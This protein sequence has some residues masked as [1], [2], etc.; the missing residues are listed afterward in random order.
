MNN[1]G[2]TLSDLDLT[3]A[4]GRAVAQQRIDTFRADTEALIIEHDETSP[5][6]DAILV[7]DRTAAVLIA[8]RLDAV[9]AAERAVD[10]AL[11]RSDP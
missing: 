4:G 1:E 7:A 5:S 11:S 10:I 6:H 8:D 2:L 9:H 3:T